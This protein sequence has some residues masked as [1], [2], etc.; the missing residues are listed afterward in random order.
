[1]AMKSRERWPSPI[2]PSTAHAELS[3]DNGTDVQS[4]AFTHVLECFEKLAQSSGESCDSLLKQWL[5]YYKDYRRYQTYWE[6]RMDDELARI[7]R[8]TAGMSVEF[9]TAIDND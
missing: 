3:G 2:P 1:M 5:E 8:S 9:E 6:G 4:L 7:G